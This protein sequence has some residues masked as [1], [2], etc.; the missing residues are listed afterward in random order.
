[1]NRG[2]NMRRIHV[3][4]VPGGWAAIDETPVCSFVTDWRYHSLRVAV[5]NALRMRGWLPYARA[6]EGEANG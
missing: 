6:D 2:V 3:R 4:P 1:M 5:E